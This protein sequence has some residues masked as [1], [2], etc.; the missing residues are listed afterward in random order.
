MISENE[1][2][3]VIAVRWLGFQQKVQILIQSGDY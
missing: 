2:T 3:F 1:I